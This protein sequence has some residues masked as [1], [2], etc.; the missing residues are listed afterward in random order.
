MKKREISIKQILLLLAAAVL[1][2][3]LAGNAFAADDEFKMIDLDHFVESE[4]E[5]V[6]NRGKMIRMMKPVK[7]TAKMKRLPEEK[8]MDY[9]YVAMTMSGLDNDLPKV[10]HRMFVES[11]KGRIIPVYVEEEAV[12]KIE[13]NL[14]I[15]KDVNFLAYHAYSYAKGPAMLV[16]DFMELD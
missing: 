14:K 13:K 3:V 11:E 15:E 6:K 16:V 4:K 5:L 9:I 8:Q 10:R 1:L 2:T 7:F 12:K